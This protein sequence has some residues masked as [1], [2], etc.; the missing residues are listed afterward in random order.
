M[1]FLHPAIAWAGVAAV[2]LP[3]IIHFLFRRRRVAVEW[4]AMDLLREAVKRTNRRMKVEQWIVLALRCLALLA[5]GLAI[6]VPMLDASGVAGEARRLV[7]VVVDDVVEVEVV[8]GASVVVVDD[9]VVG[10]NA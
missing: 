7:V 6:A 9:V 3:I 1:S 10:L 2:A 8:V 5:A 4:A